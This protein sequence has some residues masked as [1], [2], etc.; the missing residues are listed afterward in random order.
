V[1]DVGRT[2]TSADPE[3][4]KVDELLAALRRRTW[5]IILVSLLTAGAMV[6]L[7]FWMTP[8][9]RGTAI[10]APAHNE[11]NGLGS[12]I[13][14]ALGSVG[15]GFAA[16]AGLGM[17]DD[18]ATDEALAVLKSEQLTE[19]F[20][21]ENNLM[22]ELFPSYWDA[23]NGK[24]KAGLKKV[25]TL[26]RGYRAF[27]RIRK[28]ERDSKT[29]LIT[30]TIDWKDRIKAA[31]WTNRI[32]QLLN[33]EMRRRAVVEADASVGYLQKEYGTVADVSTRE[34]IS[35]LMESQIKQQML[36]HVTEQ[37]ALRQITKAI[38]ADAD[39]PVKP[40]KILFVAVGIFFGALLGIAVA[41]LLHRRESA[42]AITGR[43]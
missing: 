6:G 30:L 23:R 22:P 1:N 42:R 27:D 38:P 19:A 7:A 35:K 32:V 15:G 26:F 41:L 14:S 16:L 36:A 10:L 25:P 11:K 3:A 24:W 34:A 43:T 2:M 12:S 37:Y 28:I 33:E 13:G 20:I 29:G 40:N 39:A 8:I 21:T 17:N 5:L 9:Y 18:S 4:A 31:D